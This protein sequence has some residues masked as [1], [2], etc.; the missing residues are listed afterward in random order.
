MHWLLLAVALCVAIHLGAIA[1]AATRF[2]IPIRE[3]S[4]GLG[5]MLL[6]AGRLR[7]RTLPV[8][9]Q[10]ILKDTNT[11]PV[12]SGK[13][14][15]ALDLQ[16]LATRLAIGAAGPFALLVLAVAVLQ[17]EGLA[18]FASGFAQ[19]IA[20]GFEPFG[21]AQRLLRSASDVATAS[22]FPT[23][24][25]LVAAKFAAVN[26]LPFPGSNG[27]FLLQAL[28]ERTPLMKRWA[29]LATQLGLLLFFGMAFSWLL[30]LAV[31]GLHAAGIDVM[32]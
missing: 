26:L 4:Y 8:G 3:F 19:C 18:T 16:P 9:G 6:H 1:L 28:L 13:A 7:I 25:A 21:E 31:Y 2:G 12:E 22:P 29:P 15:D 23:L 17:S 27:S 20:G 10:L 30:A 11:E 32:A 5:P 24:L 14:R